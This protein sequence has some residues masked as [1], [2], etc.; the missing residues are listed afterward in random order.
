MN[1]LLARS[2]LGA[3][4]LGCSPLHSSA[5]GQGQLSAAADPAIVAAAA[6][7]TFDAFEMTWSF[8]GMRGELA[9]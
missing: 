8:R 5:D 3:S 2:M 6:V 9:H 7:A 4:T 1:I